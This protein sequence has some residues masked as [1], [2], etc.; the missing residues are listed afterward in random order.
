[1]SK[2]VCNTYG[3]TGCPATRPCVVYVYMDTQAQDLPA[4]ERCLFD[5][6]KAAIFERVNKGDEHRG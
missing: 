3:S 6:R 2:Y 1:M 4:V 5:R